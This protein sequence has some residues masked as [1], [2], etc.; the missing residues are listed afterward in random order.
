[1]EPVPVNAY[2][3]E[4]CRGGSRT[5]GMPWDEVLSAGCTG[6]GGAVVW[7]VTGTPVVVVFASGVGTFVAGPDADVGEGRAES[8]GDVTPPFA[9]WD[10]AEPDPAEPDVDVGALPDVAAFAACD[11]VPS[12]VRAP[13][14]LWV[15]ARPGEEL[16]SEWPFGLAER[17]GFPEVT[18]RSVISASDTARMTHQLGRTR[19][20]RARTIPMASPPTTGTPYARVTPCAPATIK[21]TGAARRGLGGRRERA[22]RAP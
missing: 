5:P 14:G 20:M 17:G 8:P 13:P 22:A 18:T 3:P 4:V 21:R 11:A 10:A 7:V 2:T 12:R 15:G 6:D 9:D 16:A 19:G 1:M